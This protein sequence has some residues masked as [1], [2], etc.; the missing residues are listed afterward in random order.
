YFDG[1]TFLHPGLGFRITFPSGWATQNL[2]EAVVAVNPQQDAAVQLALAGKMSAEEAAKRFAGNPNV[3]V[4]GLSRTD[5]NALPAVQA[6]FQARAEQQVIEGT[7][8]FVEHGG[9]TFVLLGYA[10]AGRLAAHAPAIQAALNSFAAV[11]PATIRVEPSRIEIVT[12]DAP[13]TVEE[14]HAKHPSTIDLGRVALMN[15]F[16]PGQTIPAG[17]AMKRVVGGARR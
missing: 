6:N 1:A 14:F 10:G 7:A 15:G 8:A 3:R 5:V 12:T 13:M 9:Q 17:T 11:D 4:G 2:P 16:E